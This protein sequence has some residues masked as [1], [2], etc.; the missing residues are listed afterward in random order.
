MD[1]R[2]DVPG[3]P[4]HWIV[5]APRRLHW[6]EHTHTAGT[7]TT[8]AYSDA[9]TDAVT[10]ALAE[11][12]ADAITENSVTDNTI[13]DTLSQSVADGLSDAVTYGISDFGTDH[14][15]ADHTGPHVRRLRMQLHRQQLL[16]LRKSNDHGVAPRWGVRLQR[17]QHHCS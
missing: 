1:G 8:N 15:S 2:R 7:Y 3:V 6:V 9:V 14:A 5:H 13:T 16:R 10:D 17:N 11:S 4:Q 12:F